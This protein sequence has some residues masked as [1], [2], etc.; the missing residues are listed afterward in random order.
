[1]PVKY[2]YVC[3]NTCR[4]L[5]IQSAYCQRWLNL[6][7]KI[8]NHF[9]LFTSV[10]KFFTF[11]FWFFFFFNKNIYVLVQQIIHFYNKKTY[12]YEKIH[13]KKSYQ[14]TCYPEDKQVIYVFHYLTVFYQPGHLTSNVKE[15]LAFSWWLFQSSFL[16]ISPQSSV[17]L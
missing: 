3:G 16:M 10:F 5:K 2:N 1:M 17:I 11:V 13:L 8:P 7:A 15:V 14:H 9:F 6:E 4:N 12:F